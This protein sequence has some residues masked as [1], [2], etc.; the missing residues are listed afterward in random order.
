MS[1]LRLRKNLVNRF[2]EEISA[3]GEIS[4]GELGSHRL[5]SSP[6]KIRINSLILTEFKKSKTHFFVTVIK[7]CVLK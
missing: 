6:N 4:L 1:H 3:V 2:V 5:S 7:S